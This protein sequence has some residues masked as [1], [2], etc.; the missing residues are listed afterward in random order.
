[1]PRLFGHELHVAV[2]GPEGGPPVLAIHS[3]GLSGRQWR[4]YTEVLGGAGFRVHQP[5]LIGYG[6]SEPWRGGSRFHYHAD[7][8]ALMELARDV[9]GGLTL[10]GH[11]Y[12]GHLALQLAAALPPER[13]R[14]VVAYEPVSWGVLDAG[15]A[16][17]V[18]E[19]GALA[20]QGLFDEAIGGTEAWVGTFVDFWNGRGAWAQLGEGGRAAMMASAGKMFDEVRSLCFDYTPAAHYAGITAPALIFTGSRSPA[21]EQQV[22]ARLVE[23]M[24]AATLRRLEGAG[25][26][27]AVEQA[28]ALAVEVRDWLQATS[29]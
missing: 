18:P 26:M 5:D 2:E 8:M 6:R 19:L 13:V 12:G 25:H 27:G 10:L 23:V 15:A 17:P 7:L 9:Q 21:A 1:M 22:C 14:A 3:S 20:A 4:R 28:D 24:P 29:R 16:T 11:S